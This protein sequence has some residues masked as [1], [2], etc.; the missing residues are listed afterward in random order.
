MLSVSDSLYIKQG[1]ARQRRLIFWTTWVLHA[2]TVFFGKPNG[3][4][5]HFN[6]NSWHLQSRKVA[7]AFEDTRQY[8]KCFIRIYP[9]SENCHLPSISWQFRPKPRSS[10]DVA[11]PHSDKQDSR[12]GMVVVRQKGFWH[13]INNILAVINTFKTTCTPSHATM[14]P[15]KASFTFLR[16]HIELSIRLVNSLKCYSRFGKQRESEW[17]NISF[18]SRF[19]ASC[20]RPGQLRKT[21]KLLLMRECLSQRHYFYLQNCYDCMKDI[22]IHIWTVTVFL[23]DLDMNYVEDY[24]K[25]YVQLAMAE[26]EAVM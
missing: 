5:A 17:E 20:G 2:A 15:L 26:A 16:L 22:F 18:K 8:V 21:S 23:T 12:G 11:L 6:H 4:M 7:A 14:S 1:M 19:G 9:Y 25:V 3:D 10:A 13:I 24:R